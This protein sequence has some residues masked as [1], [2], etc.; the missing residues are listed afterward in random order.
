MLSDP[1]VVKLIE[2]HFVPVAIHNNSRDPESADRKILKK[3]QEPAWNYQVMRFINKDEKDIIPR[4]DK[5]FHKEGVMKRMK[6]ALEKAGR[7]VPEGLK[8]AADQL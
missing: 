2:A 4:K 6:E 3:F 8:Q 1:D 5:I 7:P